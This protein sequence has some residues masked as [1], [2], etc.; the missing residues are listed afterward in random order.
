M[1]RWYALC[2]GSDGLAACASCRRLTRN[3]GNAEHEPQQGFTTPA[4][5]GQHCNNYIEQPAYAQA[6]ITPTDTRR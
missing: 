1:P 2:R 3:N 4:L 5:L 6:A